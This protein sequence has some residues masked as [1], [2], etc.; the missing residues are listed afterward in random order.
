MSAAALLTVLAPYAVCAAPPPAAAGAV[1]EAVRLISAG[2]YAGAIGV[3]SPRVR[4]AP[5]DLELRGLLAL[6]LYL[7]GQNLGA[8]WQMLALR[9]A[10]PSFRETA[11]LVSHH[12]LAAFR[13]TTPAATRLV[14]LLVGGGAG[15]F[16]WLGQTYQT[17]GRYADATSILRRG[18]ALFPSSVPLLDAL[19]FNEWKAGMTADAIATY[20]RAI[21]LDP[22]AW[23]LYFN[24]G[25]VY[26]TAGRYGNA[27]STWKAALALNP[28]HP[29]LPGLLRDA[30]TRVAR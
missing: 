17:Y 11:Y 19:G 14:S 21:A 16:V 27:V 13:E 25:W 15:R 2:A 7:N 26:Y 20:A 30:E 1:A 24:L 9:R 18:A 5:R 6:A 28:S 10:D 3:L 29:A 12:F 4:Q 8:E 22:R 23:G